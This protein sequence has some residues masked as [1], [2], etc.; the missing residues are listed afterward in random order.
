MIN[1]SSV[2]FVNFG[3]QDPA[4]HLSSPEEQKFIDVNLV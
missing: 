2:S 3:L 4:E 1:Y